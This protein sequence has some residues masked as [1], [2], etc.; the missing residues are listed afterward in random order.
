[1][2]DQDNERL[3][4]FMDG[5]LAPEQAA[6]VEGLIAS[7]PEWKAAHRALKITGEMLR[8]PVEQAA[9]AAD[10][11][12]LWRG[13]EGRLP[14]AAPSLWERLRGFMSPPVLIGLTAAAAVAVYVASRPAPNP[15]PANGGPSQPAPANPGLVAANAPS[16]APVAA[17]APSVAPAEESEPVIIVGIESGGSKT[18]LVSQPVEPNGAT[19]IWLLDAPDAASANGSTPPSSDDDPI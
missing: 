11:D 3:S 19:V 6:E 13:I 2:N 18:G 5:A 16:V 1:M 4:L 14:A 15:V 17:N 9:K 10:F 8:A 12:G 7:D